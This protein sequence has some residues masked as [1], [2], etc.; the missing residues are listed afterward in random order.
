MIRLKDIA[1]FIFAGICLLSIGWLSNEYYH[2]I[3]EKRQ[4]NGMWLA[5]DVSKTQA[6]EYVK[7]QD[8]YGKWICVNIRGM[9]IEEMVKTCEH[10]ASHEIFA[11]QC[12]GRPI[13]C[14][15]KVSEN[16]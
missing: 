1:I 14:L 11:R 7:A 12:E 15:R 4:L 6:E 5:G 8:S 9:T 13:E 16:E 10:E 3:S 2:L